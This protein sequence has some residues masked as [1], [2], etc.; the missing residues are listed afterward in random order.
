MNQ[1]LTGL[2]GDRR[3][4]GRVGL[5][6]LFDVLESTS[7][8]KDMIR[9]L[10]DSPAR[11]LGQLARGELACDHQTLGQLPPSPAARHL[12]GLLARQVLCRRGIRRSRGWSCGSRSSSPAATANRCSARSLIGLFCGAAA[13]RATK[14]YSRA[15]P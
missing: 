8:P 15:V 2:L 14:R 7:S 13:D 4:C 11:V 10:A 3:Q 5:E 1:R 6:A 9:W 12:E